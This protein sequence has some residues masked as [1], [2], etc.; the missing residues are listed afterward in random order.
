MRAIECCSPPPPPAR[1]RAARRP[2]RA[3]ERRYQHPIE[4]APPQRRV[5]VVHRLLAEIDH[6]TGPERPDV[7]DPDDGAPAVQ[8]HQREGRLIKPAVA[9]AGKLVPQL[10]LDRRRPA[11][12]VVEFAG[13]RLGAA[14]IVVIS[15]VGIVHRSRAHDDLTGA[16]RQPVDCRGAA[17]AQQAHVFT[18]ADHDR[19]RHAPGRQRRVHT[20]QGGVRKTRPCLLPALQHVDETGAFIEQRARLTGGLRRQRLHQIDAHR[21][22]FD[23][24]DSG[25]LLGRFRDNI[26]TTRKCFLPNRCSDAD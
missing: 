18:R 11:D 8:L 24:L 2:I 17:V 1:C 14:G 15:I 19:M 13:C 12:G 4:H 23:R 6:A 21:L 16:Q 25:R 22:A 20:R 10:D 7:V 26:V 9:H 3:D 5:E